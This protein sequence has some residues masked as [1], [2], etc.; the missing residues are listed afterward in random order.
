M[1]I[2]LTILHLLTIDKEDN[3]YRQSH[4]KSDSL[5]RLSSTL[6]ETFRLQTVT[7]SA[8]AE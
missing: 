3:K 2:E 4:I 6:K 5:T 1:R 8:T 7:G